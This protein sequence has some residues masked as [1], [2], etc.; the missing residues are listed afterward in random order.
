MAEAIELP[1]GRQVPYAECGDPLGVPLLYLHGAPGSRLEANPDSPF[2]AD[3]ANAGVRCIG[4]DRPG[5]GLSPPL[6]NRDIYAQAAD[7][8]A[9][10]DHLGLDRFL[11]VGW[12]FGGPLA[13][14][15]G[16]RLPDRIVG[17]GTI[18][19][20]APIDGA[21]LEG[22]GERSFLELA[23]RDPDELRAQ[24]K[25]LAASMRQDPATAS[26]SM[27]GPLLNDADI[28]FTL[29]P[30]VNPF[31]MADLAESARAD[32]AGYADDC[33]AQVADWG[34]DLTDVS[35][36]VRLAH[37]TDDRIIPI[38]HSR[39]LADVLPKASFTEHQGDGHIS[40]LCHLV[41]LCEQIKA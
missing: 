28:E 37:G 32:Y 13:L 29:R 20:I 41:G 1:D 6:A 11:V 15:A 3:L 25:D 18:A 27:I 17:V 14:A 21:G 8:E 5:Y 38:R 23:R 16:A 40:V 22:M 9:F 36:P 33:I 10:A 4:M 24:M 35:V 34:F 19:S 7:V 39:Y 26:L 30:E 2:A 12:S 31:M